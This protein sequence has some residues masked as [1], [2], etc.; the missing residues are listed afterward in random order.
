M[1]NYFLYTETSNKSIIAGNLP[2]AENQ[3]AAVRLALKKI[4][5]GSMVYTEI[6]FLGGGS[7][8]KK[9]KQKPTCTCTKFQLVVAYQRVD[10]F[11]K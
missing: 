8:E 7:H 11:L 10:N 2:A 4:G 5:L 3:C 6:C 1:L 9:P